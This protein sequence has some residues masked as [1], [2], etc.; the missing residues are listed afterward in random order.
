MTSDYFRPQNR[1]LALEQELQSRQQSS[2]T[3]QPV[4]RLPQ[5]PPTEPIRQPVAPPPP[6]PS[7]ASQPSPH[8]PVTP[9]EMPLPTP[10]WQ[11]LARQII[12]YRSTHPIVL[13]PRATLTPPAFIPGQPQEPPIRLELKP[14]VPS[15]MSQVAPALPPSKPLPLLPP[16]ASA[17]AEQP[18]APDTP[19]ASWQSLADQIQNLRPSPPPQG[20]FPSAAEADRIDFSDLFP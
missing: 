8:L 16:T 2:G 10:S 11:T 18:A 4:H 17:P 6:P 7:T 15:G 12:D 13:S 5:R 20:P 19:P 9:P 14:I 3:P 1:L